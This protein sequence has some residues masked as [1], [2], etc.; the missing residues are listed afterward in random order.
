MTFTESFNARIPAASMAL[1]SDIS[2]NALNCL[3]GIP[4]NASTDG[5]KVAPIRRSASRQVAHD[6]GSTQRR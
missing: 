4:R 6:A 1:V 2:S 5:T 3:A